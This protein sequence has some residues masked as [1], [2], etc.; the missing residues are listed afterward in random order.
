M[1]F[2]FS[3]FDQKS[4]INVFIMIFNKFLIFRENFKILILFYLILLKFKLST[5]I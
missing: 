4:L 5:N 1:T 2:F 3:K